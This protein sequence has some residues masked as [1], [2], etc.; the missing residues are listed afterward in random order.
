VG[1]KRG[2]GVFA[3]KN[4]LLPF[5]EAK[6]YGHN[7]I[8][9]AIAYLADYKGLETIAQA[10]RDARIMAIARAAFIDESGAALV[11]RH[12][13]LGGLGEALFTPEGY[14]EYAEDLLDRMVRPTLNDLVARVGR[15]HARKLGYDDRLFGTMRLALEGGIVP[16]NLALGAAAG[17]VSLIKRQ[18]DEKKRVAHL[19]RTAGGLTRKKLGELLSA[20]WGG[21]A[22]RDAEALVDLTW[23]GLR[24][25]ETAV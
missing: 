20:I 24:A 15:D 22:G 4:D 10:G 17:V 1:Y 7:A 8:H 19:P 5:E 21:A 25:L 18:A 11:R 6:L 9:A 3:E 13:L 12:A 14:R 2:I 23:E 16:R